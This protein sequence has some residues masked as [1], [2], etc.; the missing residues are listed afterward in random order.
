[1]RFH[2]VVILSPMRCQGRSR[3]SAFPP[4]KSTELY[5]RQIGK[6]MG[7]QAAEGLAPSAS[8][9]PSVQPDM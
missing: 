6:V 9:R 4:T 8:V 1:M 7:M 3:R 2:P 5:Y